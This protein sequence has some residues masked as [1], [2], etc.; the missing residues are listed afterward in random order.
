MSRYDPDR[1]SITASSATSKS[2]MAQSN[3]GLHRMNRLTV[4]DVSPAE[5]DDDYSDTTSNYS[6]ISEDTLP[7]I[8]EYGHTYHGS[9]QLLTPNDASEAH[10]LTVQHDLYQLCLNGNLADSK[11]PLDQYTPQDPMEILDVG[12]GT[13]I[14]ACDMAKRYP[15]TSILGIDLSSALLP[16]DVPPNVTFEIADATETWPNRTYD[17]IH[18]R[19]L[20][21][22]GVRDWNALLA[23]AYE[24]LNPGGQIEIAEIRPH[25]FDADPEHVDSESG[26]KGEVGVACREYEKIFEEMCIK[27]GVDYDPIPRVPEILNTLGADLI[28]VRV[29][30]LPIQNWG[31]DPVTQQKRKALAEMVEC[32]IEN[33]TLRLFGL[34][35]WEEK[36][37]RALLD[38]VREEIND[39]MLRSL[40]KVTFVTARK[41]I[42]S[43]K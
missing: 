14:W 6:T 23:E 35:G 36:A 17:F 19:S 32:G 13:G 16:E 15:Q 25:F 43:G 1:S 34:G 30:W 4:D 2:D 31:S 28:R 33:W 8:R 22:G 3:D 40:G 24:H 5:D 9:G 27:L 21:G 39:P 11:L 12:A 41:E 37:T 18:M 10:R 29:D 26:E 38:R 7:L 20:A 42:A